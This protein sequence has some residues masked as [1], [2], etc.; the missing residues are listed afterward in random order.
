MGSKGNLSVRNVSS[1]QRLGA[2]T[3]AGVRVERKGKPEFPP[4]RGAGGC[5]RMGQA[6]ERRRLGAAWLLGRDTSSSGMK[7]LMQ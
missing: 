3:E 6:A 5:Q 7:M 4:E 1:G 2:L